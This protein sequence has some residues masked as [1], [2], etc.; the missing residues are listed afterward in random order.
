MIVFDDKAPVLI[1]AGESSGRSLGIEWPCPSD[2]AGAAIHAALADSGQA[3][4]VAAAIDCIA[5]TRTFEDSG[6]SMGT[7]SPDNVPQSYARAAGLSPRHFVYADI[8][9]Q[10][11]QAL[12]NTYAPALMRGEY[13]AV[14]IAGAEATGTAKR[15]RK[16]GKVLDWRQSS[17]TTFDDQISAFPILS[18]SEIRHAIISMPLAYGLIETA[19]RVRIGKTEP[20]YEAEIAALWAAFSERSLHREHAQFAQNWN[21]AALQESGGGNYQLTHI[22]RRWMVAQDAC[23]LGAA[24]ILTTAGTAHDLNI[25]PEKMIWLAGAAEAAEPP[26]SERR[27]LSGSDAQSYAIAAAMDQ[28][29]LAPQDIGAV[30][31][32]SCFPCAVFAATDTFG[33][34][35]RTYGDYTLTGGLS[36]FGGPGNGYSLHSLVAMVQSLR[37]DGRKPALVTA[38]GGVMSKQAVGVYTAHQPAH[39]WPGAAAKGYQAHQVHID[40]APQ[41]KGKI[42]TYTQPVTK[43]VPGP[44][45]LLLEM[46]TGQRALAMIPTP[47]KTDLAGRIVNVTAGE[48]R[49]EAVLV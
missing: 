48:K 7:G 21:A 46:E 24:L 44:A 47:P 28:A 37:R 10:S 13:R 3:Q 4:A 18:R 30:D 22:Y 45:T 9:G 31:I 2:L 32:Y 42:L 15:A 33:D 17:D 23:D 20:E 27:N 1:A 34:P 41:G 26:I 29:G 6:V 16:E 25:A 38:N 8:G 12:I 49:H 36:F 14:L 35:S 19:R 43:D 39:T 5:A 11:P 40:H